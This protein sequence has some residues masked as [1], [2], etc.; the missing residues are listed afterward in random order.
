MTLNANM[1]LAYNDYCHNGSIYRYD[2]APLAGFPL[3][4]CLTEDLYTPTIFPIFTDGAISFTIDLGAAKP[5]NIIA[6][7]KHNLIHTAKW[8]VFLNMSMDDPLGQEYDSGLINVTPPQPGFGGLIWGA[9]QWGDTIHEYDLSQYNRHTYLP[10]PDTVIARYIT[11][12]LDSVANTTPIQFYRVWA[13]I[14]YQPSLNVDYGAAV[15]AIDET[16]VVQ[17]ASGSRQYGDIVQRR[18]LSAGFG[19]LPRAEMLYNIVGGVYLSSGISRPLICLL[20]PLD[21]TSYY[22]EAV[23]GNLTQID[24]AVYSSWMNWST[25]FAINEA[26]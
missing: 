15:T 21:P 18:Q 14:A 23:Y 7:L 17:A 22:A 2:L 16:K 20:E 25:T 13:S 5:I 11:I 19:F 3:E 8:E 24:P 10:L 4:N 6:L 9:F 1:L 12:S 26:V